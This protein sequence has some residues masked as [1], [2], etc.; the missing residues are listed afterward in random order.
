MDLRRFP[1]TAL[2]TLSLLGAAGHEARAQNVPAPQLAQTQT[3]KDQASPIQV[4]AAINHLLGVQK[5]LGVIDI[6]EAF[7]ESTVEGKVKKAMSIISPLLPSNYRDTGELQRMLKENL[8]KYNAGLLQG[9]RIGT[10][11]IWITSNPMLSPQNLESKESDVVY[12]QRA[13]FMQA[14]EFC[15]A[16]AVK[17]ALD[18]NR[19]SRVHMETTADICALQLIGSLLGKSRLEE[20]A[21]VVLKLRGNESRVF[22]SVYSQTYDPKNVVT[23]MKYIQENIP[24]DTSPNSLMNMI[25]KTDGFVTQTFPNTPK[26]ELPE[27][28]RI[29]A[30]EF[31]KLMETQHPN[32][33]FYS[34]NEEDISRLANQ[35]QKSLAHIPNI[36]ELIQ[37]H[38]RRERLLG[39]QYKDFTQERK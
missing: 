2:T 6:S 26:V 30:H 28:E 32:V 14:H 15:H 21:R 1:L 39:E 22:H 37:R 16:L 13:L 5:Q 10:V 4:R 19:Q 12:L 35:V 7:S 36:D 11:D 3:P 8:S 29:V 25:R 18:H 31:R 17:F 34:L 20:L 38:I 27:E 33:G 23:M 24:L 9:I